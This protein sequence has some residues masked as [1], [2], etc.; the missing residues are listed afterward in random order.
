MIE[1]P[2]CYGSLP[3]GTFVEVLLEKTGYENGT[4]SGFIHSED[5]HWTVAMN[6]IV[7]N[8][9]A[10]V[11]PPEGRFTYYVMAFCLIFDSPLPPCYRLL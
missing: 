2:F 7:S 1:T 10:T 8:Y 3:S 5:A 11:S 6:P 9:K 4:V